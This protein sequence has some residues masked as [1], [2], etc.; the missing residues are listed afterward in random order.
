MDQ[1]F[2]SPVDDL[3]PTDLYASDK[4][5]TASTRPW[6]YVNMISSL[7]GAIEIDGVSGALGGPADKRVFSA[8]RASADIILVGAGTVLAENYRRPQTHDDL[9]KQRV[10][11]GQTRL[12]RIA[13]VSGSLTIPEDHRV[14]DEQ[15]P[16]IVITHERS[17][18]GRRSA[19][20]SVADVIIAGTDTVDL[21]AALETLG[22]NGAKN[23]LLE[24]GPTLNGAMFEADLIDEVCLSVAPCVVGG[25]GARM[26]AGS[27]SAALQKMQ[28]AR[29][30]HQDGYLFVRYLRAP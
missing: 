10:T 18:A 22:R 19:L 15:A 26:L 8:I 20:Q 5:Q 27:H 12:P 9:Q 14:F 21:V 7:D 25:T 6:V 11:R 30:L 24:G 29:V 17:D 1:L 23:V 4:R 2:P 16:P 13:I 3:D 28:L